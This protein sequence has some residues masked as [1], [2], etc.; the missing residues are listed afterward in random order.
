M[1][2]N[3]KLQTLM[4]K[5]RKWNF[6]RKLGMILAVILVAS[7]L[8]ILLVTSTSAIRSL[9]D[10]SSKFAQAQLAFTNKI[11][12]RELQNII[13]DM[14]NAAFSDSIRNY[15]TYEENTKENTLQNVNY[16]YQ[17]LGNLSG[18]HPAIDYAAV[19]KEDIS[20]V[21]YYGEV[22][23]KPDFKEKIVENYEAAKDTIEKNIRFSVMP[24]VFYPD[25]NVLNIYMPINKKY[26]IRPD[27]AVAVMVVGIGA[28]SLTEYF[29]AAEDDI[30][31]DMYLTDYHG[32]I[33][34]SNTEEER[35]LDWSRIEGVRGRFEEKGHLTMYQKMSELQWYT[36]STIETDVLYRDTKM[37]MWFLIGII[38]VICAGSIALIRFICRWM[39]RPM[40]EITVHMKEV[41]R[42]NL[43]TRMGEGYQGD[44]FQSL[45]HGFNS[46]TRHI[47]ELMET[48]KEE[49]HELEQSKLNALQSQ[50]KPHF[51]YNTLECIHWQ[52]LAEGN[53]DV[54]RMVKA[55]ANY[56]RLCLSHGQDIITLGQELAHTKNYLII[57]NMRYDDII[58]EDIVVDEKYEGLPIPKMTLQPLVENAIY[59]GL[60]VKN[61]MKGII[62]IEAWD[63]EDCCIVSVS[64]TGVGM[65]EEQCSILNDTIGEFDED[66]GYGVRNVHKRIEILFGKGYGLKYY[67]NPD[68][69]VRVEISLPRLQ[70]E[71]D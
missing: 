43:D 48:V 30:H 18:N 21:L 32:N 63:K 65:S 60:K 24:K 23:T 56:Y 51:L 25:E 37:T 42:G 33:L 3:E 10:K 5:I 16:A 28:D 7:N 22:W 49:Q 70:Q 20:T 8:L 59:H 41:S 53:K 46:M 71:H 64:D 1:R 12:E 13:V 39:Y 45:A 66:K 58:K 44:D 36:V 26:D 29:Q 54:S 34:V 40:K 17:V 9:S 68:R 67:L 38:G 62:R 50:I 27:H 19:I 4:S 35:T 11:M 14:E 6:D 61:G 52:A 57:Q 15:V 31:M 47:H 55:L 2:K 69:G